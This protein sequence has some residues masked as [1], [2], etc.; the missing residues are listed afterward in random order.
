MIYM[1]RSLNPLF[2][3]LRE[4]D[5]SNSWKSLLEFIE[6]QYVDIV[7]F[8]NTSSMMSQLHVMT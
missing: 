7:I 8:L 3:A 5:K 6:I 4:I 2:V 1:G